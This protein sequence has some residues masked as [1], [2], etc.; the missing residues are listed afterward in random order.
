[1]NLHA[2]TPRLRHSLSVLTLSLL[3]GAAH[4]EAPRQNALSFS[5][6]AT[7]EVTQ[8]LL[9]VTLQATRAGNQ[10]AAVQTALKQV[11]ESALTEARKATQ[12]QPGIEVRTGSF[13]VQPSYTNAGRISGWQGS[14]Q[15]VLEGT[16][17]TR[18]SQTAGKLTQL[19]V[20]NMQYGLSRGLRERHEAALTNEAIQRFRSRASTMASAFGFKGYTL[21]EVSVSS[22]EPGFEPRPYMMAARAKT[23]EAADAALPVEPGKG[24]LSVSVNGQ[25]YLTP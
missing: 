23:M 3:V 4:A 6:S 13:S 12:G 19:N 5:A 1:M 25:V 22:T 16:D 14:A 9:V 24:R 15:L 11:M 10:A 21:G 20:V 17:T 8:D 7:E 18:I 2:I